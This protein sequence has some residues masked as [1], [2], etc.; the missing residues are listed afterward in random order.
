MI[1][2]I[3]VKSTFKLKTF[4]YKNTQISYSASGKGAALVFLHGF[5]ENKNMWNSYVNFFE[6]KYRVIT[7]D[8]FGHGSSEC[9]GYVHTMEDQADMV[10]ALLSDLRI[11]K[12]TLIGHSMGGYVALAFGELYPDQVKSLVLVNSSSRADSPERKQNRDRAIQVVK[13]N[14][15][16]F[17]SMAIN[18]LFTD[19]AREQ[20]QDQIDVI[21]EEALQTSV[22]GIVASLEGMKVR[23]DREVLLHFGPY[24]KL[25]VTGNQDIIASEKEILDETKDAEVTTHILNCG[26][27][28]PLE[29]ES[30]LIQVLHSFLKKK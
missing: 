22:Q 21:R 14:A 26:H 13:K 17:V 15:K 10:H 11:R 28:A 29:K 27:M 2:C 12:A 23:N 6:S 3:F 24:S 9:F 5:L 7:I 16:T 18:N 25:V 4:I 19:E 30:E 8:L 1:C 20:F